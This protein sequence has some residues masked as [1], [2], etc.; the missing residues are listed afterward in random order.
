LLTERQILDELMHGPD[1][2]LA[3]ATLA[4][5]ERPGSHGLFTFHTF[6]DCDD[7]ALLV[8]EDHVGAGADTVQAVCVQSAVGARSPHV[9]V[10]TTRR[11]FSV[12]NPIETSLHSSG[13][14]WMLLEAIARNNHLVTSGFVE[15]HPRQSILAPT[16][17]AVERDDRIVLVRDTDV[18]A[19]IIRPC[20]TNYSLACGH[21]HRALAL[22]AE[23]SLASAGPRC[24]GR[25][26]RPAPP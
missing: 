1:K 25:R 4:E 16:M 9:A 5:L 14:G 2:R 20:A 12:A 10:T 19:T 21:R 6:R 22:T 18:A 7:P 26:R 13:L 24:R 15:G 23:A 17:R 8:S 3:E 11:H